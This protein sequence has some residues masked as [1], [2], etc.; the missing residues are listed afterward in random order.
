MR[1][2]HSECRCVCVWDVLFK[3]PRNL[4]L[5]PPASGAMTDGT[6]GARREDVET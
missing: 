4:Y 3:L 2:A 5:W 1:V 6:I